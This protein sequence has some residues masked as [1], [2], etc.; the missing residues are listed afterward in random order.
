MYGVDWKRGIQGEDYVEAT[1][2]V[3]D[4]QMGATAT[5]NAVVERGLG[6]RQLPGCTAVV[7][8]EEEATA[9]AKPVAADSGG[10][11]PAVDNLV[12][13]VAQVIVV[14]GALSEWLVAVEVDAAVEGT[15]RSTDRHSKTTPSRKRQ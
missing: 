6:S 5:S 4:D 1:R 3:A 9:P 10:G 14:V 7:A 8:A 11:V 2:S 15:A 13:T 12:D